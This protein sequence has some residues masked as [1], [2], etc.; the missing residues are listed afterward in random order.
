MVKNSKFFKQFVP[1]F[2][3][4]LAAFYGMTE[5]RKINYKFNRNNKETI[6]REQLQKLGIKEE[7]YQAR[8]AVSLEEEYE[9]MMKK[10]DLDDWKNIRGPRPWEDT[11]EYQAHIKKI[12]ENKKAAKEKMSSS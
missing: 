4:T 8:T 3:L 1:F 6:Y 9:K 2:A 5:F 7:D 11:S 10:L 12:E